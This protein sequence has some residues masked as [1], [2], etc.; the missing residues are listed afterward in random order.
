MSDEATSQRRR[1]GKYE[2]L[3]E[4]GRG[5]MG[6][7]YHAHDP[8]RGA[9]ETLK[10]RRFFLV[11]SD[12]VFPRAA[13]EAVKDYLGAFGIEAVGEMYIPLGGSDVQPVIDA[14]TAAQP[15]VLLNTINGDTNVSFFRALRAAG[16]TPDKLPTISFSIGEHELRALDP[17]QMAGD[18]AAATYF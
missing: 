11:G 3:G 13:N 18:F 9:Y 8:I 7:V 6:I 17:A 16:V 5:G 10:K 2:I 1:I 4:L 15:D 14:I 12:Y